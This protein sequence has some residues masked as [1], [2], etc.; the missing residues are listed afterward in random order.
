MKTVLAMLLCLLSSLASAQAVYRCGNTY[1]QSPCPVGGHAIDATD[2]RSA[3]QRAEA[4]RVV[5]D[6]KRLAADMRRERLALERAIRPAGAASLSG[7]TPAT[8]TAAIRPHQNKKRRTA[9]RPVEGAEV[10]MLDMSTV[11]RRGTNR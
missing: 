10:V 2:A 1:S 3:A 7:P 8:V 6:E 5:A 9:T 4:R 11:K